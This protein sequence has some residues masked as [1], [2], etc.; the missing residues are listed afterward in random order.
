MTIES[1]TVSP[2]FPHTSD[3]FDGGETTTRSV[4]NRPAQRPGAGQHT[5]DQDDQAT[6]PI[7]LLRTRQALALW[8][9]YK[10]DWES[11]T[12]LKLR[13]GCTRHTAFRY[14]RRLRR[15]GHHVAVYPQ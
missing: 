15:L 13:N 7:G 1:S 6:S 9:L 3:L 5:K 12:W 10:F 8:T 14:A 2:R 11:R 4:I